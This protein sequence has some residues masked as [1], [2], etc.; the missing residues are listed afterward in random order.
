M[1]EIILNMGTSFDN[2]NVQ[3]WIC[4]CQACSDNARCSST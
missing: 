1:S 4:V 3:S 2:E